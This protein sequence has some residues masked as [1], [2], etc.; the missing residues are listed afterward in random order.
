MRM[1]PRKGL[2]P[3]ASTA[4]IRYYIYLAKFRQKDYSPVI[5]FKN[6]ACC[7]IC[8][9]ISK[10]LQH[11]SMNPAMCNFLQ[12]VIKEIIGGQM[13]QLL[14]RQLTMRHIG[15]LLSV[16][17]FGFQ[18]GEKYICAII[19]C[20]ILIIPETCQLVRKL[21]ICFILL[22]IATKIWSLWKAIPK[23]L[24]K[25]SAEKKSL[26]IPQRSRDISNTW[27]WS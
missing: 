9:I 21:T 7:V 25:R 16:I 13:E 1:W 15:F 6:L 20:P 17:S 18:V 8:D 14:L 26:H 27:S 23:G 10:T 22:D 19:Q 5:P 3:C 11:V 12:S 24:F 2:N 4:K